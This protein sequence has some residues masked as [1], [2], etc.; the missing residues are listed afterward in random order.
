MD[1][2]TTRC[3]GKMILGDTVISDA[4][5]PVF[6]FHRPSA[7]LHEGGNEPKAIYFAEGSDKADDPVAMI[8]ARD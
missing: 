4:Y 1:G 7:V 6:G 3:T 8:A 2:V 5:T